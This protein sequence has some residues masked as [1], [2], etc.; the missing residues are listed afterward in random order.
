M[1]ISTV[2][3]RIVRGEDYW[4]VLSDLGIQIKHF[5]S[6]WEIP[7]VSIDPI[8]IEI[9]DLATGYLNLLEDDYLSEWA[10]FLLASSP[11]IDFSTLEGSSDGEVLL[12][13][14]WDLSFTNTVSQQTIATAFRVAGKN[15]GNT[16]LNY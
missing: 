5:D 7:Y 11:L 2:I 6:T 12:S 15:S 13:G 10:S 16:H 3:T 1:D 4:T 8:P 14:L 9:I